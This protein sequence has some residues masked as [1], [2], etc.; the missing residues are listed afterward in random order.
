MENLE[1]SGR[2]DVTNRWREKRAIPKRNVDKKLLNK[3]KGNFSIKEAYHLLI[4]REPED[5]TNT[6]KRLWNN[7]WKL[8]VSHFLWLVIRGC[9]LT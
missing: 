7:N 2:M 5:M 1:E 9:S 8:K 6:W 3:I 4:N